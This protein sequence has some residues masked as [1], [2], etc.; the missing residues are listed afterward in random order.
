MG[1]THEGEIILQKKKKKKW[2]IV[3]LKQKIETLNA[4]E[5][6]PNQADSHVPRQKTCQDSRPM[7]KTE[8]CK[9]I[10]LYGQWT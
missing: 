2:N 10:H 9:H 3:P 6:D 4:S 1:I 8:I 5:K 7:V